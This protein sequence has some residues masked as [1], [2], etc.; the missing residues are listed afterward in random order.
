MHLR[1]GCSDARAGGA[2]H[3]PTPVS[4]VAY[5]L[6]TP[7]NSTLVPRPG[8]VTRYNGGRERGHLLI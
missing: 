6:N 8:L 3:D 1:P 7:A 5:D 2:A 4:R